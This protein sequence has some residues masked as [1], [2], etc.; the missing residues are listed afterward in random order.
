M[1]IW[2]IGGRRR[3]ALLAAAALLAAGT[4][5]IGCRS[6]QDR[7]ADHRERAE[8]FAADRDLDAALIE[9]RSALQLSPEDAATNARL[10]DLLQ[11]RGQKQDALFFYQEAYRLDPDQLAAK[12][13]AAGLL[14]EAD[15]EQAERLVEEVLQ[16]EPANA[17]AHARKAELALARSD[18]E[19]ALTSALT[20]IELAPQSAEHALL[21]GRVHQA[22]LQLAQQRNLAA[23]DAVFIAAIDAF[24]RSAALYEHAEDPEL[25]AAGAVVALSERARTIASWPGHEAEVLPALRKALERATQS[26]TVELQRDALRAALAYASLRKDL[27][28]QAEWLQHIVELEPDDFGSWVRLADLEAQ[29]GQSAEAVYRRLLEVRPDVAAPRALLARHLAATGQVDA[30]LTLLEQ[31]VAKGIEPALA[32]AALAEI[33]YET[34]RTNAADQ[35]V[36]RL[37]REFPDTPQAAIGRAN[38]ELREGRPSD[39]AETLRT[40]LA[41]REWPEGLAQLATAQL[42]AGDRAAAIQAI[43]RA[44]ALAGGFWATGERIRLGIRAAQRDWPAVLQSVRTIESHGLSLSPDERLIAIHAAYETGR[45]EAARKLLEAVVAEEPPSVGAVLLFAEREGPSQPERARALLEAALAEAASDLRLTA[46]VIRLDLAAGE[47]D[48]AEQR[49]SAA[50]EAAQKPPP[51]LLLLRARLLAAQGRSAEAGDIALDVLRA[52][53]DLQGAAPLAAAIA[54][55]AGR[56]EEVRDLLA[57]REAA[58]PLGDEAL[59]TLARLQLQTGERAAARASYEK[60]LAR[61]PMRPVA[62]ND[63][64]YLLADDGED[65]ERAI[66]LARSAQQAM[67]EDPSFADTLG[68]VYLRRGLPDAALEQF[69]FALESLD[70]APPTRALIHYHAGLAL[71]ELGRDD[72]ARDAF[73]QTIALAPGSDAARSAQ[74]RLPER[75]PPAVS[76]ATEP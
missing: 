3:G 31:T 58:Q 75:T 45:A 2:G 73:E 5:T 30:A 72:E 15:T 59:E 38:R 68:F 50:I 23:D 10:A 55:G 32:L 26:G 29:R 71:T 7:F 25:R 40:A 39:A 67:P 20:A 4:L 37:Q 48:R 74:E 43:D 18:V 46:A 47:T 6:E 64:A 27:D 63:L 60:L 35:A 52:D 41:Q 44:L 33:A 1:G 62:Q 22:K 69:R 8:R 21:L 34:G 14:L 16:R 76:E 51:A 56:I 66:E 13:A 49:L 19:A 36:E 57:E 17:A 12:L 53:P 42:A 9:L 11:R 24:E 61:S 28:L 70:P 54:T 65:L